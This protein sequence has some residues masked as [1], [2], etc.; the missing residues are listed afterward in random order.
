[1]F[2]LNNAQMKGCWTADLRDPASRR[3]AAGKESYILSDK[4][5]P[6]GRRVPDFTHQRWTLLNKL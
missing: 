6:P 2:I 4:H 1:M 5:K 3:H